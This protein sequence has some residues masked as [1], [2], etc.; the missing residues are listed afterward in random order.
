MMTKIIKEKII[1]Y[2]I[3][4]A[5]S[6]QKDKRAQD[7]TLTRFTFSGMFFHHKNSKTRRDHSHSER[8]EES[9]TL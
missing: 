9:N 5:F 6:P 4:K 8:S 2:K 3:F 7:Q 1:K